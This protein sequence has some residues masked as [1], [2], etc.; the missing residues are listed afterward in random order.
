MVRGLNIWKRMTD[1][2]CITEGEQMDLYVNAT[3]HHA[4][5]GGIFYG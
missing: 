3:G 2:D 4:V 5:L 1:A